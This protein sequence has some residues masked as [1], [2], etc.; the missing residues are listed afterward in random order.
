MLMMRVTDGWVCVRAGNRLPDVSSTTDATH[1]SHPS[2]IAWRT[3][4]P[5]HTH[6]HTTT[7]HTHTLSSVKLTSQCLRSL[8]CETSLHQTN[9]GVVAAAR[10]LRAP[11]GMLFD[12]PSAFSIYLKRLVNPTRKADD[13]W[14]TVKYAGK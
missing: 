9:D 4:T 1:R 7:R 14:K 8:V 13:G 2:C 6:T 12:S 3:F 10:R 11:P 5:P